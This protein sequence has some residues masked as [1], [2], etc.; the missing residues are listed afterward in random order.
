MKMLPLILVILALII[1]S[2]LQI[3]NPEKVM[4]FGFRWLFKG[5]TDVGTS[6]KTMARIRGAL[7]VIFFSAILIKILTD[8]AI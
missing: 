5:K 7:G 1:I 8:I 3:I 6:M 4:L 2:I